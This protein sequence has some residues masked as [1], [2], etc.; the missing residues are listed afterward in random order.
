MLSRNE[1]SM[2][3]DVSYGEAFAK[4]IHSEIVQC[5]SQKECSEALYE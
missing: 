5:V 4:E 3:N 1:D 2:S